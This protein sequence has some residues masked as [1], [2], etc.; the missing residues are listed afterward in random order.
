MT[1]INQ[2]ET[3]GRSSA[4]DVAAS[5]GRATPSRKH[6]VLT[7]FG[8]FGD[9][10]PYIA[11]GLELKARGHRPVIA[12]SPLY[13]EKIEAT[14]LGFHA[15]GPDFRPPQEDP[16]IVAKVMDVKKGSEFL[17]KELLMPH[18]REGYEALRE[19]TRDADLLVTHVITL[20]G[21][22]LAQKTG[23]PWISTVLAPTSFFSAY[24]PFV[25]PQ[26][27]GLVK[28]LRLS[29][30]LARGFAH[31]VKRVSD[32]WVAPVYKLRAE[33]GLPRGGHPIFEGQH[34]PSLVLALFSKV[35]G[36][37][38]PDWPPQ[39]VV[40]GFPFFDRKDEAG[41]APELQKFLDDGPA[42]I[43]FTL[44]SSAVF[45]AED[46]YRESAAAAARLKRRAV[47]L[48]GDARN[49][50]HDPLPEG[51]VAFEYAPYGQ[52]L[53]RAAAIVHQGGVGTTGQALR[54]GVPTL[55]VPF[56]HDQ[57]DNAARVERLGVGRTLVRKKYTTA[58]VVRELDRLLNDETYAE[59]ASAVGE[60]VRGEDG[61][62]T[63]ADEIEKFVLKT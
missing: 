14:G 53:P 32:K 56:N 54:A 34:S 30:L 24:D 33:L 29:P 27:P 44:G 23:I 62:R 7:T 37:P 5:G 6:I 20:A 31:V 41:L 51:V 25:P 16:E 36:A 11:V 55:I 9:V 15:V 22:I 49:M 59:R 63:A 4:G 18:L 40:T 42:P 28:L 13:R 2:L 43:V 21:P 48:L 12:T 58:N 8:S 35:L 17:F 47:L 45:V 10:H 19:A 3:E 1:E 26:S 60:I 50:P 52:I 38:Q 57:P 61:S 46:F 39:T